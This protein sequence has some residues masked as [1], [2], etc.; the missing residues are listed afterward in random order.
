MSRL[1]PAPIPPAR[2][3]GRQPRL[4]RPRGVWGAAPG[5]PQWAHVLALLLA[6]AAAPAAAE[7][8]VRDDRG[9]ELRLVA[10]PARIVSLL[11]SLTETVCALGG[12]ERLVG[13]D[14]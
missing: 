11:P 4:R 8:R 5:W 2:R 3:P 10:P 13:I 7:I 1:S 6:L 12:C 14:R 9:V